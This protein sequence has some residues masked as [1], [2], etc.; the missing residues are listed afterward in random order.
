MA[1]EEALDGLV[2][3]TYDNAAKVSLTGLR[4]D[5]LGAPNFHCL[6]DQATGR[7]KVRVPVQFPVCAMTRGES[8]I[9]L[10][11]I[12]ERLSA[13][14]PDAPRLISQG[15]LCVELIN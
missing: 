2:G 5:Q 11:R 8:R 6:H 12:V 3:V 1:F 7:M 15:R 10:D 4:S 13:S 9:L 14:A